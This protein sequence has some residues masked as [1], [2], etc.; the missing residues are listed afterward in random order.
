[1]RELN[2]ENLIEEI[3][4]CFQFLNQ[5]IDNLEALNLSSVTKYEMLKASIKTAEETMQ[6]VC[7]S[8]VTGKRYH[9]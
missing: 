7:V 5:T 1:M 8:K 4:D 3:R 9:L 6:R 2:Q